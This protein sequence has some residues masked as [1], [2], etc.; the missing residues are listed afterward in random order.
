MAKNGYNN[1]GEPAE[2]CRKIIKSGHHHDVTKK[3]QFDE[4]HCTFYDHHIDLFAEHLFTGRERA[5]ATNNLHG[6]FLADV[7][8]VKKRI[9]KVME[10]DVD[11]MTKKRGKLALDILRDG[12]VT[13]LLFENAK[14]MYSLYRKSEYA[15][16]FEFK[17]KV[18]Q[19]LCKL[20][21]KFG[22][23]DT[24]FRYESFG[25]KLPRVDDNG[26]TDDD[27]DEVNDDDD[28]NYTEDDYAELMAMI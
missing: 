26:N 7:G 22:D 20:V 3:L 27:D 13:C 28:S 18:S 19:M 23:E 9:D 11:K 5:H 14:E 4:G 16:L 2:Y 8:E 17:L 12:V 6:Y 24:I 21:I 1:D 25:G 15:S 10:L